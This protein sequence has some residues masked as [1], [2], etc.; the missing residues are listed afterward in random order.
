MFYVYLL[1]NSQ[2]GTILYVGKGKGY[3]K[4]KHFGIAMGD[5]KN[6]KANPKL[7]NKIRSLVSQNIEVIVET[8]FESADEQACLDF[9]MA[10]IAEIGLSNLCNLTAGGEGKSGHIVS[11]ETRKKI[12]D[13]H[14]GV[15]IKNRRIRMNDFLSYAEAKTWLSIH[16]PNV[17]SEIQWELFKKTNELPKYIPKL[18]YRAYKRRN[19][20]ITWNDFVNK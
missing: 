13:A 4:T 19:S 15:K 3:R 10:K 2:D 12:A 16:C 17:K 11:E 6:R 8:I 5:G 20:W 7:Y 14:R 18:P 1:K 9:E